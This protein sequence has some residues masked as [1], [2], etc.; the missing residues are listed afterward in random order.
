MPLF[1]PHQGQHVTFTQEL[2]ELGDHP[3]FERIDEANTNIM[4]Y[5][6]DEAV[7]QLDH[8]LTPLREAGLVR[9]VRP[10]WFWTNDD[11]APLP[12]G[13]LGQRI[14]DCAGAALVFHDREQA[15]QD[16]AQVS[17]PV[18]VL[19]TLRDSGPAAA[20][21]LARAALDGDATA[22]PALADALEETGHGQAA[23]VRQLAK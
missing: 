19:L 15:L 23:T 2:E 4:E 14:S 18:K 20:R 10:I 7:L 16:L 1:L 3:L 8:D 22:L 6:P 12:R 5:P 9:S 11:P 13:G 17:D 21:P